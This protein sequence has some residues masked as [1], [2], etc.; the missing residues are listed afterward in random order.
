MSRIRSLK[1][2]FFEDEDLAELPFWVRILYEGLWTLA[3]KSGRL[4]DR[5]ARKKAKIFPYEKVNVDDGL[6]KLAG[7]KRHSPNHPPFIVRYD[8]NGE[9]YIQVLNFRKH[10]SPHHTEK[11]SIIPAFNGELPVKELLEKGASGDAHESY[12]RTIK[13]K[14]EGEYEGKGPAPSE[15]EGEDPTLSEFSE[16]WEAYPI[17]EGKA[18]ALRAFRAAR[19]T[20][21]LAE[22]AAGFNGY[23]AM[24]KTERVKNNFNRKPK[25]AA[26]FLRQDRWR[27]YIGIEYGPP[28]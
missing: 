3:D 1:P 7:P 2:D 25:L 16:F 12:Q 6:N 4:E 20:A 14:P 17:K 27:E 28:L 15:S 8:V 24:L 9:K 10:Q 11:E 23:M 26:T 19:K 21:S 13:P 5:P 18:D 22:I